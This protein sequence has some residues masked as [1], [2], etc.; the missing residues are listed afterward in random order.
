MLCFSVDSIY[1]DKNRRVLKKICLKITVLALWTLK[2]SYS[3]VICMMNTSNNFTQYSSKNPYRVANHGSYHQLTL[4][5][6]LVSLDQWRPL[7]SGS[8]CSVWITAHK[9][10]CYSSKATDADGTRNGMTVPRLE[11]RAIATRE[12][13]HLCAPKSAH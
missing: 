9:H 1:L 13:M 4:C 3:N 2:V 7:E 5:I 11:P 8:T 10:P 12:E 6:I